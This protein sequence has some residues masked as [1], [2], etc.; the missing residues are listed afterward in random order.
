[1]QL[2]R[3]EVAKDI[4]TRAGNV[5]S[6]DSKL[7]HSFGELYLKLGMRDEAYREHDVLR[8]LDPSLADALA[9]LLDVLPNA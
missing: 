6:D 8:R 9:K 7:H 3:V 5:N 4:L 1:M 2:G